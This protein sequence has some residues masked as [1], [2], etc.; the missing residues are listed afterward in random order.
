MIKAVFENDA[1]K[2]I[3]IGGNTL[4]K[5]LDTRLKHFSR[6]ASVIQLNELTNNSFKI[7]QIRQ[8][9]DEY[10]I[11]HRVDFS[12]DALKKLE[13]LQGK[14][15]PADTE[16]VELK[17]I[18]DEVGAL[19]QLKNF[20]VP[21]SIE[22]T[23]ARL[24]DVKEQKNQ[25][26]KNQQYELA[27][28]LR[29]QESKLQ[30]FAS[31]LG[32]TVEE[33]NTPAAETEGFKTTEDDTASGDY[34]I[35]V[36]GIPAVLLTTLKQYIH[37]FTDY[38]RDVKNV[39]LGL[40]IRVEEEILKMSF[41]APEAQDYA[42]INDWLNEYMNFFQEEELEDVV[43][44]EN[45]AENDELKVEQLASQVDHLRRQVHLINRREQKQYLLEEYVPKVRA[46]IRP[47]NTYLQDQGFADLEEF[48]VALR[49]LIEKA[50][51]EAAAQDIIELLRAGNWTDTLEMVNVTALIAR[52][53]QRNL[54][55]GQGTIDEK[56]ASLEF[57]KI[58]LALTN[59]VTSL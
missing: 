1:L 36:E 22:N 43:E 2:T 5:Y 29:D 39:D 32:I 57:N 30:P 23:E 10:E 56:D 37:Y 6:N 49:Q 59:L 15:Y 14:H 41:S 17:R 3:F 25:A 58:A 19:T 38:V 28:D 51:L 53:N 21:R 33:L 35:S 27:A 12:E 24:E 44:F 4:I 54:K 18:L 13:E 52:I 34:S 7:N 20:V 40:E 46:K 16:Q 45:G 26:V 47:D 42:E 31:R 8:Y 50:K 9:A 48:K 11:A 55:I